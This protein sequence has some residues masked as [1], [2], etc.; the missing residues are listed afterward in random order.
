[1]R[2][3]D[4]RS[5]YLPLTQELIADALGLSI[6]YVNQCFASFAVTAS[7]G[8]RIRSSSSTTSRRSR[9][10]SISSATTQAAVDRRPAERTGVIVSWVITRSGSARRRCGRAR[11]RAPALRRPDRAVALKPQR[12]LQQFV[13]QRIRVL[14]PFEQNPFGIAAAKCNEATSRTAPAKACGANHLVVR[15]GIGGDAAA[16]GKP[17]RPGNIGLHDVDRAA[18]DS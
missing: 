16:L 13:A 17:A 14:V 7:S 9:R 10:S 6:P 12:L 11:C 15:L 18:I 8:S 2:L 4:E 5:F 3:A 1:V